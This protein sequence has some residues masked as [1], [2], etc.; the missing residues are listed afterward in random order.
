MSDVCSDESDLTFKLQ[1]LLSREPKKN[2]DLFAL[3]I[4]GG[5]LNII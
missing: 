1:F 5:D 3:I 2:K 4:Y